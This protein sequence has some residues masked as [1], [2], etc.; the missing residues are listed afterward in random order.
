MVCY[1]NNL[2]NNQQLVAYSKQLQARQVQVGAAK[3]SAVTRCL[4]A[5]WLH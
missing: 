1:P 5:T 2:L 4:S 3:H